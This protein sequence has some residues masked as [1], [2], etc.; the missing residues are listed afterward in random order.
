MSCSNAVTAGSCG[1][2]GVVAL[3]NVFAQP[4]V[5]EHPCLQLLEPAF[6]A[7]AAEL[8]CP[9]YVGM[10]GHASLAPPLRPAGSGA[11]EG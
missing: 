11:A 6:R 1:H 5:G 7:H 2:N 9:E 3:T 8:V 4:D 10:A